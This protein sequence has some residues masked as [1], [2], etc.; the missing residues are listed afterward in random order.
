VEFEWDG[1]KATSN[2]VKHGVT[3]AKAIVV[4]SDPGHVDGNA[5][6]ST[7]ESRRKAVGLIEGRLIT[8]VYTMRGEAIRII[9]ARRASKAERASYDDRQIHS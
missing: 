7:G 1:T 4:F 8:V 3:F 6:P 2:Y 5:S 9:S